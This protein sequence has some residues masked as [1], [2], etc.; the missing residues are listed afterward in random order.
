MEEISTDVL[1][2]GSGLAGILAALEAEKS[3]LRVL[4]LGKFSI[5]MGTNSSISNGGFAAAA[6]EFAQE[7]HLR[8]TLEC[9][10]GLNRTPLVRRMVDLA[11]ESMSILR[12][13]GVPL[14]E[15]KTG[16]TIDR[17][18]GSSQLPGILLI[19]AL[20][21]R[22]GKTGIRLLPGMVVFD[23]VVEEGEA[24]GA[25]GFLRDGK[26]CLIH[27]KAVVLSAGGGGAIYSRNDNQ[28]SILGDG[29]ALA[30]RAGLALFDLE[31]VQFFPIALAEPRLSTILFP[32]PYPKRMRLLDPKGEVFLERLGMEGNLNRAAIH[33]RDRFSVAL[34]EASLKGDI[35][36]DLTGVSREEWD[37]YPL[38]F[39]RKSKFPFHERPFLVAP[40]VHFF[41]GG[42]EMDE[43]AG[44]ALPGLFAAG[45]VAWG[46]HGANRMGGNALTECAVF[47]PIAGRSAG[48]YARMKRGE[49]G[50]PS[51]PEALKKRWERKAK[52]Y[53]KRKRGTFEHPRE[54]KRSLKDL[55]WR[56]AGIVREEPSLKEGLSRLASIEER[57]ER[58]S[59]LQPKDLFRKR[60]LE[61]MALLLKVILRG[62]LLR[63][64]S[65]GSFFRRDFPYQDDRNGL[66]HTCYRLE[67]GE[68]RITHLD[69]SE[70]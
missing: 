60:E 30:L 8:A 41:M 7:D 37:C 63:I 58:I 21:D 12:D 26:P 14:V 16:Y 24:R 6:S 9:G 47:G 15:K 19:R 50:E 11:P 53:E 17:P 57:I 40:A 20:R 38:N 5:G 34:F 48:E 64:E 59:P 4:L 62:S 32:L 1:V 36:C 68:M 33:D 55:A 42:V 13:L 35:Y 70:H 27:S 31:F 66:K 28:R 69:Q 22:L 52:G 2:I 56:C 3:G 23:L 39:L 46:I 49:G 45:E 65:R 61:N 10:K 67:K 54:I 51:L 29:Y 18:G 44:T 43:R 25:L